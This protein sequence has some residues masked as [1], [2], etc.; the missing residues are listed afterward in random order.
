MV[1]S[2]TIALLLALAT[3][4]APTRPIHLFIFADRFDSEGFVRPEAK[5]ALDSVSDLQPL[6]VGRK[7]PLNLLQVS[8]K[9]DAD[10]TV[11][12]TGREQDAKDS[13]KRVVHLRVSVGGDVFTID[14]KDD[15]GGWRDAA[16]DAAKQLVRWLDA[17]QSR[18]GAEKKAA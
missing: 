3:A 1:R 4:Q 9:A 16:K 10:V 7:G 6:L 17:N 18:I 8:S 2:L 14:G 15:D 5:G 11:E 12:V 13:D